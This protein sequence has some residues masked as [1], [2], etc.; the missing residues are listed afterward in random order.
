VVAVS[1]RRAWAV[2]LGGPFLNGGVKSTTLTAR[3]N[4]TTWK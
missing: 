1:A 4:G 2:G 3:W